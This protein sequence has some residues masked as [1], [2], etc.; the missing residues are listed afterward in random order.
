MISFGILKMVALNILSQTGKFYGDTIISKA[1]VYLQIAKFGCDNIFNSRK[2]KRFVLNKISYA[3]ARVISVSIYDVMC[4]DG[5]IEPY[6]RGDIPNIIIK[7][8]A[9]NL[10]SMSVSSFLCNTT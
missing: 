6:F 7:R 8:L 1:F 4:R 2:T 3:Y 9:I 10:S 5:V